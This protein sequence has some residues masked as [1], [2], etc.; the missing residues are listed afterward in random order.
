MKRIRYNR[1]AAMGVAVAAL[2]LSA[3]FA[4][5]GDGRTCPG[6]TPNPTSATLGLR[7]FNDCPTSTL[8]FTNN[9][10][11]L[12]TVHDDTLDCF[13]FANRHTWSFSTDG[14]TDAQ[15]ENCSAYR[16]CADVTLS[17]TGGGEGG[18][19]LSPWWTAHNDGQFMLNA[20][21]GEVAC[22]GGR[23]PFYS[24]TVNNG[25]HYVKGTTAHMEIVYFPHS[26][27]SAD[28]ATITYNLTY[29][30][31]AYTSGPLP[32][33]QGNAA[34]DPPHGLWGELVP[35]Y[36]GGYVQG[37]LGQGVNVDFQGSWANICFEND[38]ATPT[39]HST[40]GQLKTQYR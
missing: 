39:H 31:I 20:N 29:A 17:G 5:A 27:S 25:V 37:Y 1:L 6:S 24:F 22:F 30:S 16:F 21:T 14:S 3:V 9:Y 8:T 32:F 11:S 34:E 38:Q 35:A 23:L 4:H 10:P 26:L 19:R 40:W 2:A 7:D 15:F 12:I 13:G 18:L 33:D 28:P 36:A